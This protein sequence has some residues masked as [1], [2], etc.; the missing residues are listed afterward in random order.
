[1]LA[2]RNDP[3]APTIESLSNRERQV[4]AFAAMGHTNKLIG[5]ELGVSTSA[6]GMHL[7]RAA[8]KLRVESRVALMA[9]YRRAR[10]REP[11]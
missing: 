4:V 10:E 8:K 7:K 3:D 9:S 6:V 2:R 5:Y 11:S 1:L